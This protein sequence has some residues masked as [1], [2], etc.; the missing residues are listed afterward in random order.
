MHQSLLTSNDLAGAVLFCH[1][2]LRVPVRG[3]GRSAARPDRLNVTHATGLSRVCPMCGRRPSVHALLPERAHSS[4]GV[5]WQGRFGGGL[6]DS[7]GNGLPEFR[8]PG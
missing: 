7:A 8:P 4:A 5:G 3:K 1:L 6:I 2:L